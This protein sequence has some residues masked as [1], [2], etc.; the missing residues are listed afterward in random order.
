M[1]PNHPNAK[2]KEICPVK[3]SFYWEESHALG[4]GK[5]SQEK[6][7]SEL[8]SAVAK[9]CPMPWEAGPWSRFG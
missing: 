6:C 9:Y 4:K 3:I 7:P 8:Q 1:P 2:K 5:T